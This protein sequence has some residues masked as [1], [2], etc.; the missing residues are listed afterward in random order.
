[1]LLNLLVFSAS[2]SKILYKRSHTKKE[3][4]SPV[5]QVDNSSCSSQN[6][7]ENTLES[8]ITKDNPQILAK[9]KLKRIRPMSVK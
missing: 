5:M 8:L 1:M 4:P 2:P 9:K 7:D 6:I 3:V